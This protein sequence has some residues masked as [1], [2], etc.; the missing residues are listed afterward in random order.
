VSALQE[1]YQGKAKVIHL[2][3]DDPAAQ[4]YLVK[5]DVRGTPTIVLLDRHGHVASNVAGW[6]GEQQV[7]QALDTLVAAP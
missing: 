4:P 6:P 3:V 2:N 7:G 1:H 5:Y